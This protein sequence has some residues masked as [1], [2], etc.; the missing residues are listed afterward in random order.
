MQHA[1]AYIDA[2]LMAR[3]KPGVILSKIMGDAQTAYAQ[4]G[5]PDEWHFHHQGGATGYEAREYIATPASKEIVANQQAFAW[6][7]SIQGV[8][9]EDTIIVSRYEPELITITN[10]WPLIE[11]E[12]EGMIFRR[13]DILE[14]TP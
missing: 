2:I 10:E 8:K 6:N 13:P 4:M 11:V 9:S 12:V 1:V 14:L 3:T 7:P 5:S